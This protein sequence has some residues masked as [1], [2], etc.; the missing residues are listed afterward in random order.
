MGKDLRYF[1]REDIQM[2]N[3]HMK[4]CS[5]LLVIREMQVK[6]TVRHNFTPIRMAI[7]KKQ[8]TEDV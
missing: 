6:T 7:T 4:R 2:S 8:Q 3:M 1:S 5:T